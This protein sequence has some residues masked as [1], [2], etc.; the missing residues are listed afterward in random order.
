MSDFDSLFDGAA[1]AAETGNEGGAEQ[2]E[3][4]S[5]PAVAEPPEA[6]SEGVTPAEPTTEVG[7]TPW[8]EA[9]L[10]DEVEFKG[11]KMTLEE[12]FKGGLRQADYTRK[13]QAAAERERL[14]AWGERVST[15]L[16]RDPVGT[17]R[18]LA[19]ELKL[20]P[21]EQQE[22]NP[23]DEPDPA[24][25]GLHE[26]N[27]RLAEIDARDRVYAMQQEIAAARAAHPDFSDEVL[28]MMLEYG[29]QGV[30]LNTEDAYT[31]WRGKKALA[32][33][34]A[35]EAARVK[36]EQEAAAL[37]AARAAKVESGRSTASAI[38]EEKDYSGLS[39]GDLFDAIAEE[40]FANYD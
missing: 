24:L 34:Q 19:Q 30:L 35:A 28:Q 9:H 2:A 10:H 23:A 32:E 5:T 29:N 25:V 8:W 6:P 15:D 27:Q 17:L 40:V 13:Q 7:E 12:A 26:V 11:E 37:A 14:A 16:Q 38:G 39:G 1:E 33:A 4:I 3:E 31:L 21:Q 18:R 20:I 36:A 22:F